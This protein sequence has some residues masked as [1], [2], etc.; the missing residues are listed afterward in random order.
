MNIAFYA[1][2]LASSDCKESANIYS[3]TFQGKII[4]CKKQHAEIILDD[5]I[6]IFFD[7][8]EGHCP[9]QPGNLTFS[10]NR[11]KKPDLPAFFS[12]NIAL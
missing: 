2:N 1:V 11:A 4:V 8:L 7:S 6:R 12:R 9:A 5:K 3:E 10:L